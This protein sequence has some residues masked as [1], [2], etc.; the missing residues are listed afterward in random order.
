PG[1]DRAPPDAE[2]AVLAER[3]A[4]LLAQLAP[5][6]LS[7]RRLRNAADEV[8]GVLL[9]ARERPPEQLLVPHLQHVAPPV[10]EEAHRGVLPLGA[11]DVAHHPGDAA[12]GASIASACGTE[13]SAIHTR[14]ALKHPTAAPTT[15][16]TSLAGLGASSCTT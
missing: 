4:R 3:D 7:D 8:R 14:F 11:G 1:R 15:R 16:D 9:A 2:Q 13:W 10:D 12:Y 5:Q 6:R